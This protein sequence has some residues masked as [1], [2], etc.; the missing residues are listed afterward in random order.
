LLFEKKMSATAT[1][2]EYKPLAMSG[3][4]LFVEQ[5]SV[6][7]A[8]L[9]CNYGRRYPCCSVFGKQNSK[10]AYTLHIGVKNYEISDL[11]FEA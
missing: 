4:I 7:D 9:P 3:K 10:K 1:K 6:G 5:F 8:T 2:S 11:P